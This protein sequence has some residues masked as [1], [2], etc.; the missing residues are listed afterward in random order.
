MSGRALLSRKQGETTS[1]LV[2][3]VG[4]LGARSGRRVL[5][6]VPTSSGLA[7]NFLCWLV[8]TEANVNRVP[9]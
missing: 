1:V 9:Q 5:L 2:E 6:C 3:E 4:G 8:Q 7:P